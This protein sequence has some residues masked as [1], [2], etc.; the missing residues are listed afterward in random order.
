MASP[1]SGAN[2]GENASEDPLKNIGNKESFS[3]RY[4]GQAPPSLDEPGWEIQTIARRFV[5]QSDETTTCAATGRD[6]Q[7]VKPHLYV[8]A[9]RDRFPDS[10]GVTAEH[11]HFILADEDALEAW[12]QG[13]SDH[14]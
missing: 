14:E 5:S 11:R 3:L 6:V 8:T 2:P 13:E 10:R 1:N 12:F 7:L 9:R 4:R